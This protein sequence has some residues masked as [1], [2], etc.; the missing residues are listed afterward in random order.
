[1]GKALVPDSSQ[2]QPCVVAMELGSCLALLGKGTGPPLC[3]PLSYG[4]VAMPLCQ[5]HCVVPVTRTTGPVLGPTMWM[6]VTSTPRVAVL[7]E[8][9]SPPF[10]GSSAR[11]S[12]Q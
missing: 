12:L 6:P 7:A 2:A 1:M 10:E 11:L 8:D 4:T 3:M 9:P 5:S